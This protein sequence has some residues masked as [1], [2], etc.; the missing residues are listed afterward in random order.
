MAVMRNL[1]TVDMVGRGGSKLPRGSRCPDDA[2]GV[3]I[4]VSGEATRLVLFNAI[5]GFSEHN[6]KR[7]PV[8]WGQ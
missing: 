4:V 1:R 7:D 6:L 2:L 3:E 8:G 5:A